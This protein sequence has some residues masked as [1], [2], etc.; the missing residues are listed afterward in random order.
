LDILLEYIPAGSARTVL[1]KFGKIEEKIVRIYTRQILTGL[2]HL[3]RNTIIHGNLKCSNVLVDSEAV[4]K[5]SDFFLS[6]FLF[7]KLDKTKMEEKWADFHPYWVAPELLSGKNC[8]KSDIWS[9]GCVV[10]E[11]L[12]SQN[13]WGEKGE[14]PIG[15]FFKLLSNPTGNPNTS[16]IISQQ[17]HCTHHQFQKNAKISWTTVLNANL[18]SGRRPNTS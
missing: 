8:E 6:G 10:I 18:K 5:L 3:H 16:Q 2:E 13:P 15:D 9:I 7:A 1:D 14:L 11:M 12:T 17:N 4:I